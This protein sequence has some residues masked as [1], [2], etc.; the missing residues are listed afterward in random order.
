[1]SG[2][3]GPLYIKRILTERRRLSRSAFQG[4]AALHCKST[5]LFNQADIPKFDFKILS[6]S[7]IKSVNDNST[8]IYFTRPL[9]HRREE[10]KHK[11]NVY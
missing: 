7:I 11:T 4:L 8:R 2:K 9:W 3:D 1:M 5:D 10:M 6:T